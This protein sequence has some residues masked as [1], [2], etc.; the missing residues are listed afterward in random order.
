MWL[1]GAGS[2][3][4]AG[5]PTAYDMIWDFKR[6]IYCSEQKK[7]LSSCQDLADPF[8]QLRIQEY[9]DTKQ[10]FPPNNSIR[11]YSDLFEYVHPAEADRRRYINNMLAGIR[12]SYGHKSL[13]ALLKVDKARI[14]W[15][16]NF[17]T[18]I[19]DTAIEVFGTSSKIVIA[20]L[21]HPD[22]ALECINESRWPLI[23]KLHGDFRSR[24]L[25]NTGDELDV[26]DAKLRK[27]LVES[28]KH[29]GLAVVGYSGRDQSIINA[30]QE[31]IDNGDGFPHGIYWFHRAD[32]GLLQGVKEFIK[33][34]SSKG[35]EA[36]AISVETFDE[37][38]GD[39]LLLETDL[40]DD[41]KEKLK[42][43][44]PRVSDAPIARK[45]GSWPVIRLNAFPITSAPSVCRLVVC[46]IG[47]T[48]EVLGAIE[49]NNSE[50]I[51]LRRNVGVIAF[52]SDDEIK[53][54]F[55]PYDITGFDVYNIDTY[56]L[57]FESA[58]QGLL[59][60]ALTKAIT[61]SKPLLYARTRHRHIIYVDPTQENNHVFNMLKRTVRTIS[62]VIPDTELG[63]AEAI[64]IRIEY[65][66]SRLWLVI[67]PTVWTDHT[68]DKDLINI[69]KEFIRKRLSS[70]YN[71]NWNYLQQYFSLNL[72]YR[73]SFIKFEIQD[74]VI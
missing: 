24:C 48:K 58:E 74:M 69:R 55:K 33:V 57:S 61:R 29:T 15:T 73:F 4:A 20:D 25:K 72:I 59:Y 38:M 63:W 67:E 1:L 13:A 10:K 47:G 5:I 32:S 21:D 34:A 56:R 18:L 46:S 49:D 52:G 27:A 51:A 60:N 2:S 50:I 23:V 68:I 17:D 22:L 9:L 64:Q 3:A 11:E 14:V 40:P 31:A 26:Q 6:T 30:L 66:L 7:P 62:G 43:E 36:R 28:C 54:V 12:P 44:K 37:L 70:R 42:R 45:S 16:T 71:T 19:E 35:I 41:V 39:L 53:K 8:L 65:R